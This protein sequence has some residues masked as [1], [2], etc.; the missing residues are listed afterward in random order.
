MD[1]VYAHKG[2]VVW[3]RDNRGGSGRG[4]AFETPIYR[5]L[6]AA[7][8]A[9]QMAGVEYLMSLGFRRSEKRIGI[10]GGAT[11]GS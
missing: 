5:N 8:L 6:G 9:D 3:Q 7:E 2:Y 10:Q 11:A 1:Q 4:H